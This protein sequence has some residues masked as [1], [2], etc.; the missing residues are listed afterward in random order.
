MKE[1]KYLKQYHPNT[2]EQVHALIKADKLSIL[3]QKNQTTISK[4]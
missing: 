4:V 2:Q 1:L 3:P